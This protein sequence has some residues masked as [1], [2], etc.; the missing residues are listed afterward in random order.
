MA[1]QPPRMAWKAIRATSAGLPRIATI[2]L[3]A[4]SQLSDRY[5]EWTVN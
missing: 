5:P 2:A 1:D 4:K 3:D